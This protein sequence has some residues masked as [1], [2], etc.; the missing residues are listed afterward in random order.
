[1]GAQPPPGTS[2][3]SA[4]KISKFDED[5]GSKQQEAEKFLECPGTLSHFPKWL[6]MMSLN[7]WH[8]PHGSTGPILFGTQTPFSS[9]PLRLQGVHNDTCFLQKCTHPLWPEQ[10]GQIPTCCLTACHSFPTCGVSCIL[11]KKDS[12]PPRCL[13]KLDQ[14]QE[15]PQKLH[16]SWIDFWVASKKWL[17]DFTALGRR[18]QIDPEVDEH[19]WVCSSWRFEMVNWSVTYGG[20]LMSFWP[21]KLGF[22]SQRCD[23]H[24]NIHEL[25]P[26][27]TI[28]EIG[29]WKLDQFSSVS[30]TMA[31]FC[32][33]NRVLWDVLR[34][35]FNAAT[36]RGVPLL[37]RPK[38]CW[39]K[40]MS[41][42][43]EAKSLSYWSIWTLSVSI[44]I[45]QFL[46][47]VMFS[48]W[49]VVSRADAPSIWGVQQ[50]PLL[51]KL[52][53]LFRQG[54]S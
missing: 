47:V 39:K 2:G 34:E 8:Y 1:M 36:L 5:L 10:S 22:L 38:M 25:Q 48:W 49:L 53:I 31:A 46:Q 21:L 27:D 15:V 35:W 43:G 44:A 4:W 9:L 30:F 6:F 13:S 40:Q 23:F 28:L 14:N 32:R 50:H 24:I 41:G 16:V 29:L 45:G 20:E 51:F 12:W 18:Q 19:R 52:F 33:K 3:W 26:W 42:K 17:H 54:W 37:T 7:I 11:S